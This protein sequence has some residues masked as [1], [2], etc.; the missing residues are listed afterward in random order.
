M[1]NKTFCIDIDGTICT[2]V[3][4]GNYDNASPF[5][6]IVK[7]INCLYDRGNIIIFHTARGSVS[8]RDLAAFTEKQLH[9]WG[10]KY[11]KLVMNKPH[12]DYFI[13]DKGIKPEKFI[14]KFGCDFCFP[15][16]YCK[17]GE[18]EY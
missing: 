18:S 7:T 2:Q 6:D 16:S 5:P 10:V 12:A 15:H 1:E 8:G 9:E 17:A 14:D 13:D 11:H 4:D 3:Y